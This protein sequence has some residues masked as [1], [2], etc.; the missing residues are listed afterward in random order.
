MLRRPFADANSLDLR[1]GLGLALPVLAGAGL[2]GFGFSPLLLIIASTGAAATAVAARL[3]WVLGITLGPLALLATY[4]SLVQIYPDV[5]LPYGASNAVVLV[6]AGLLSA[7]LAARWGV[8]RPTRAA[9]LTV[10][11]AA[12]IPML[13][14]LSLPIIRLVSGQPK[15]AW[16]MTNDSA[17]NLYY[18]RILINDGGA[19]TGAHASPAIGLQELLALFVM[20]GRGLVAPVDLLEHDLNRVLQALALVLAATGVLGGIAVARALPARQLPERLVVGA[21]AS[22]VPFT[23]FV[24][25]FAFRLGFWNSLLAL[26]VLVAA[27]LA[28]SDARRHPTGA[29]ATLVCAAIIL[30]PVWTPV[31]LFPLLMGAV[32]FLR[33]WR[34]HL[35]LRGIPLMLWLLPPVVLA[36]Y[37]LFVIRP[38]L[39]SQGHALAY[40]GA[41]VTISL[42]NVVVCLL[43]MTATAAA[44]A[45]AGRGVEPLVVA[46]TILAAAIVGL[47]YLIGQREASA[48]GTWGYYPAKFGWTT[49]ILALY[50]S[51]H[52]CA[53]FARRVTQQ[54]SLRWAVAGR[55]GVTGVACLALGAAMMSQVPPSDLRPQSADSNPAPVPTPDWRAESIVPLLSIGADDGM[56]EFD[57]ILDLLLD[58]SSPSEKNVVSQL[59]HDPFHDSLINYWL[60]QQAGV[61]DNATVQGFAY[62]LD[63]HKA[64]SMCELVRAWGDGVTITTS[65][66]GWGERLHKQCPKLDFEV[67]EVEEPTPGTTTD[68]GS[69]G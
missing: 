57:N 5:G 42:T 48:T 3:G 36:W 28:L 4:V 7:G 10:A 52:A 22:L 60:L 18:T 63:S 46:L 38:L 53:S 9:T 15:L 24:M 37:G 34:A 32:L 65:T 12:C 59:H 43:L 1:V 35:T 6:A 64:G 66:P 68:S 13:A 58:L 45:A 33:T 17:W 39:T 55:A 40:D 19:T 16:A 26:A 31:A 20:P 51:L 54:P 41:M 30:L 69:L 23:W 2:V 27:W 47:W 29:T 49:S 14:T 25:G 56:S 21:I 11:G 44:V 8:V 62:T 50:V 61:S 67:H